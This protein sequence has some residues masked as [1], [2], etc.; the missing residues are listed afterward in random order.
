MNRSA[1]SEQLRWNTIVTALQGEVAILS[2]A[3]RTWISA[4]LA[5]IALVQSE[6]HSLVSAGGS[7][8]LCA[9][10]AEHCCGKGKNHL[11][12][13][14]LLF[15]LLAGEDLPADYT[16]PCPQFGPAG[17][18]FPPARRP[19][20]CIT[21]NCERVEEEL[22]ATQHQRLKTLETTLRA[23][24]ESFAHRYAGASPQGLL[25]RAETLGHRPFLHRCDK[26]S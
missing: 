12:L 24:Y 17:C 3:E 20:N 11:G 6:L 26:T 8:A 10:C 22:T 13:A 15:Y 4:R 25:I 18:L 23:L 2:A 9:S 5:A 19:Y 7:E 14:N 21:F 16:S 1:S